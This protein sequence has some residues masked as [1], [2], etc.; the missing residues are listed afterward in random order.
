[1]DPLNTLE[2][3][4]S[5]FLRYGV[6]TSGFFLLVGFISTFQWSGNPFVRFAVYTPVDLPTAL[7]VAF[8]GDEWGMIISYIGLIV[9]ISLPM[10]RVF[11]TAFL[12]I[13]QKEFLLAGI[14]GFVLIAL[15]FSFSL[16]I[17]L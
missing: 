9:L 15:I 4:I 16:G 11:L 7:E 8:M 6:L 5:K 10:I 3:K 17:E 13:K 12:F 2:L 1:M 14:A